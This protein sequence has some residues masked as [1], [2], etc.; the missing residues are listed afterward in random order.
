VYQGPWRNEKDGMARHACATAMALARAGAAMRLDS[1]GASGKSFF[2]EE[3]D[4]DTQRLVYLTNAQFDRVELC[5][6][7]GVFKSHEHL[8]LLLHPR[9]TGWVPQEAVERLLSR[10]ILYTSWERDTLDDQSVQILSG[11]AQVWVPCADNLTAFEHG[12]VPREKLRVVPYCWDPEEA[13]MQ[14]AH[15]RGK[16]EVPEGKR[17]YSIG[18]WE[19]RK[20]QHMLLG[21]FLQAYSIRDRASLFIKTSS[22]GRWTNYPSPAESVEYWL[23][24]PAVKANGWTAQTLKR[25]VKIVD[26]MLSREDLLQVH[27]RNN[28]YV[29]ASHSEA[30]DIPAFEARLSGNRLVY[31]DWGGP[32]DF[33]GA[34]D[35]PVAWEY[36]PVDL[37]YMWHGY[38]WPTFQMD[39][40]VLAL[41]KATLP[42]RR[43]FDPALTYFSQ[44]NVGDIMVR[45]LSEVLGPLAPGYG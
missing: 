14:I 5:I 37:D 30:W 12:G 27:A 18:K 28:I 13:V 10:T 40:L 1:L 22:F 9:S 8:H 25:Q 45:H 35:I 36:A 15:P 17:F 19:P 21:A 7:H 31:T 4:E 43:V 2:T 41:R 44:H 32:R 24:H 11:L 34:H 20:N 39:A 33:A 3:L 6:K 42:E 23:E 29:S 26:Q 16:E 38:M